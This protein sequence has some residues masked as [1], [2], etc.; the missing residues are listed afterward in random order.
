[1]LVNRKANTSMLAK[2]REILTSIAPTEHLEVAKA[3]KNKYMGVG[4]CWQKKSVRA[5]YKWQLE[6]AWETVW[7]EAI[8]RSISEDG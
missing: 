4:K 1:M 5:E 7:A 8:Q 2:W 3:N 6:F